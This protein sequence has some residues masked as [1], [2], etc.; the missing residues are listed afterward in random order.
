MKKNWMQMLSL[1]MSAVLL[2]LLIRQS[3]AVTD[4][5][6]SLQNIEDQFYHLRIGMQ[7]I[8]GDVTQA[9]EEAASPIQDWEVHPSGI[10]QEQKRLLADVVLKLKNWQEDTAVRLETMVGS[11]KQ[12]AAMQVDDL[13][14]CSGTVLFPVNGQCE[15]RLAAVIT[16]GGESRRVNLRRWTDISTLLPLQISGSGG[17]RPVHREGAL[18]LSSQ[19]DVVLR[20][21]SGT[22]VLDPMFRIY[23]NGAL[24]QEVEA[25]RSKSAHSERGDLI[26]VSALPEQTLQLECEP[27]S[28]IE[29]RFF[30]TDGYGLGYDFPYLDWTISEDGESIEFNELRSAPELTWPE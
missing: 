3:R 9:V 22:E 14:T 2:V 18:F 17:S 16:G 25:E 10:D 19:F 23:R 27:G 4:L 20:N 28:R 8:S 7:G 1:L 24:V 11:D 30:C 6:R 5:R 15:V 12:V 13:G 26:F 29:V 21:E